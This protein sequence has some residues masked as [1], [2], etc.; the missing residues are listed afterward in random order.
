[1]CSH[2][3]HVPKTKPEKVRQGVE[4]SFDTSLDDGIEDY[5]L[6]LLDAGVETDGEMLS[7]A[8]SERE[9]PTF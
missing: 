7:H 1:M 8:K 5:V 6:K 2:C 3:G 4:R 9:L